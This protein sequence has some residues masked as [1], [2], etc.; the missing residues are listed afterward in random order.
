M[1]RKQLLLTLYQPLTHM[2]ASSLHVFRGSDSVWAVT[3]NDKYW[4]S[5]D[6]ERV[7]Q[8]EIGPSD[9]GQ[10]IHSFLRRKG[11]SRHILASMKPDPSAIL[12]NGKHEFLCHP[13]CAGDVLTTRVCDP[14]SSKNIVPAPVPFGIAYEDEDILVVNKPAGLAI[15]PAISHPENTLGNGVVWYY[16]QQG[17]PFVFRCINRLDRDTT[18][19]LIVAKNIVA[20][21]VLEQA[22]LRREIHRTY[23]AIAEGKTDPAGTVD[24][25]IGR[26][27]R[28][29][30]ER[31]ID[32][33]NGE[34]AVT[35]Y[36]TLRYLPGAARSD[37]SSSVE[38]SSASDVRSLLELQLE[39]GRTHQIRVHMASL[40]HPLAGDTLYNPSYLRR[41]DDPVPAGTDITR[42][43]LHAWKLDFTHPITGMPMHLETPVPDDMQALLSAN[44]I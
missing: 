17:I 15:H 43:A 12:L 25:P 11:Y 18:G 40:D 30:I 39:T 3:G 26:R 8:Y 23:L 38:N 7:F 42:Q 29:L 10:D 20:S 16:E 41:P 22:L 1:S 21:C 2:E 32:P 27:T 35:H 14:V 31:C 6:M 19:L 36:K 28:S 13:V 34:R 24:A 5:H 37:I 33:E 44:S 4:G 9:E